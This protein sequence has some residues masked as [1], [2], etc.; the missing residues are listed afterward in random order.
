MSKSLDNKSFWVACICFRVLINFSR[1]SVPSYPASRRS[2]T[3]SCLIFGFCQSWL[4]LFVTL[5][6]HFES[7]IVSVSISKFGSSVFTNYPHALEQSG[8]V[9][10]IWIFS[11]CHCSIYI[12]VLYNLFIWMWVEPWL[13][14]ECHHQMVV[15]GQIH[16]TSTELQ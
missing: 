12:Y 15:L 3:T 4:V 5:Y 6:S 2:C 9:I 10:P 7:L 13:T 16:S 11:Q 14:C 8:S 1:L